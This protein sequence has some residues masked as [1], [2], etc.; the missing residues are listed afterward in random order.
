MENLGLDRPPTVACKN[1]KETTCPDQG[2]LPKTMP[3]PSF[4]L[5]WIIGRKLLGRVC[6]DLLVTRFARSAQWQRWMC[7]GHKQILHRW[8]DH[9]LEWWMKRCHM[10]HKPLLTITLTAMIVVV[11]GATERGR[12]TKTTTKRSAAVAKQWKA[13]C[14]I[15]IPECQ[16]Y[17][18]QSAQRGQPWHG[19][20]SQWKPHQQ[21]CLACTQKQSAFIIRVTQKLHFFCTWHCFTW[22][23]PF[24]HWVIWPVGH[25]DDGW[26]E[27][28][29]SPHNQHNG[30]WELKELHLRK[31]RRKGWT[32]ASSN[33]LRACHLPNMRRCSQRGHVRWLLAWRVVTHQLSQQS[34]DE[35]I[36]AW[37]EMEMAIKTAMQDPQD[38]SGKHDLHENKQAMHSWQT[39]CVNAGT[40]DKHGRQWNHQRAPT[41]FMLHLQMMVMMTLLLPHTMAMM[42]NH[43]LW[44]KLVLPPEND[45]P[46]CV[47][48][49]IQCARASASAS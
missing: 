35:C 17:H 12:K 48:F 23:T 4:W 25:R 18:T 29:M 27:T 22:P 46:G 34:Q 30:H 28:V 31:T 45:T 7:T 24:S 19:H 33:H 14:W 5:I 37:M 21:N 42:M 20:I 2:N 47:P 36:Q 32:N 15:V 16:V 13:L 43:K 49:C 6:F 26:C 44:R 39:K 8:Q 41:L 11:I 10:P 40:S 38:R 9:L 3:A 1:G